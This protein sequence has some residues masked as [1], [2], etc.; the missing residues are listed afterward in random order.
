[1]GKLDEERNGLS[2]E[3]DTDT[4]FSIFSNIH[5]WQTKE[6]FLFTEDSQQL[7]YV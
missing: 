2:Y 5:F 3:D 1:M 6:T 4:L 7:I